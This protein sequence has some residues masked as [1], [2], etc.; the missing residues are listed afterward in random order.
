MTTFLLQ[1]ESVPIYP[2]IILI[3]LLIIIPIILIYIDKL[4]VKKRKLK[5]KEM[6]DV[7]LTNQILK[8]S[9]VYLC[10]FIGVHHFYI[11]KWHL[12]IPYIIGIFLSWVITILFPPLGLVILTYMV[13]WAVADLIIINFVIEKRNK[14]VYEELKNRAELL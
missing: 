12:G 4:M 5:L 1:Q 2:K 10:W 13:I 11:G 9:T 3:I 6:G 7:E 8:K 14:I